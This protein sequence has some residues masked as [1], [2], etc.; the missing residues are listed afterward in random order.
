MLYV[1]DKVIQPRLAPGTSL[2]EN[3]PTIVVG[4]IKGDI[5]DLGRR[6][7]SL[8]L[9]SAGYRVV[10][11]GKD[12]EPESF[13]ECCE[14]EDVRAIAISSLIT[15]TAPMIRRVKELCLA[16]G[17][18]HIPVVAGG[19][20]VSQASPEY[21]NVDFVAQDVFDGL[22]YFLREVPPDGTF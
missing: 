13:V 22:D 15:V 9:Q 18:S 1:M 3:Q 17:L 7:L 14:K 20:A 6:V 8:I 4:T 12:V 11:L 19:A 10:D 5:Y 16:R 2:F 21:L